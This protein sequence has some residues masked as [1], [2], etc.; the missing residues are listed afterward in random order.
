MSEGF[1][2]D[3][4]REEVLPQLGR[5]RH[6]PRS[7]Q[8]AQIVL[9]GKSP[10][11]EIHQQREI[12]VRLPNRT[13]RHLVET[14]PVQFKEAPHYFVVGGVRGIFAVEVRAGEGAAVVP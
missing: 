10:L 11:A 5:P 2:H 9:F 8:I 12:V 6:V 4:E 14:L 1:V 7:H 3:V 13:A